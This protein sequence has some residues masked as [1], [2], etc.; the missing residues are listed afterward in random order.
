MNYPT[1]LIGEIWFELQ[2]MGSCFGPIF[3]ECHQ[4]LIAST[5]FNPIL[6]LRLGYVHLLFQTPSVAPPTFD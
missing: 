6:G 2:D 1:S 4:G 3:G 5:G